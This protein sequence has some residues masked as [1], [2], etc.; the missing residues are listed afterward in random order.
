MVAVVLDTQ[1][2]TSLTLEQAGN[3]T[4]AATAIDTAGNA[5]HST[6]LNVEVLDPTAAFDPVFKI[7]LS[8]LPDG[9]VTAPTAIQG[10]VGGDGFSR[11]ELA[12]APLDSDNFR[13]IAS[14]TSTVSNGTLGTLDPSL[15]QNDAYTLRLLVYG[16]NGSVTYIDETVSVQG[17]LK[18]GN[19]RLSFT[20]LAIPVTGIPITLTRT[21][22]TLTSNQSDDFGYGWR[23]EFRDTDLRTS[24]GK[25]SEE[26]EI[27]GRYPAFDDR[28]KVYLGSLQ[29][30]EKIVR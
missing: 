10:S 24:V 4:V 28:T 30:S 18:L 19:F 9:V 25:R 1:G 14:G 22:D 15:L 5:G 21:Y 13:V 2:Y 11:Y 26:D 7:D 6:V 8:T 27:L 23:M 3:L 20:D 29:N 12:I 16:T 17:E